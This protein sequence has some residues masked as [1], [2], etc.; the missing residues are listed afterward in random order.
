MTA[1]N[2]VDFCEEDFEDIGEAECYRHRTSSLCDP[3]VKIQLMNGCLLQLNVDY[4]YL[5]S[6]DNLDDFDQKWNLLTPEELA[7]CMHLTFKELNQNLTGIVTCL[8]CRS[9]VKHV[10][11]RAQARTYA[12]EQDQISDQQIYP[13]C[14]HGPNCVSLH[15]RFMCKCHSS[16]TYNL[17]NQHSYYPEESKSRKT[18]QTLCPFHKKC[19]QKLD[20]SWVDLWD[21]LNNEQR[22]KITQLQRIPFE[23]RLKRYV[24]CSDCFKQIYAAYALI[25]SIS[26]QVEFNWDESRLQHTNGFSLTVTEEKIFLPM[27]LKHIAELMSKAEDEVN[28]HPERDH[29]RG[30]RRSLHMV[31]VVLGMMLWEQ[32]ESLWLQVRRE[33]HAMQCFVRVCLKCFQKKIELKIHERAGAAQLKALIDSLENEK[34][35][36]N[37]KKKKKRRNK[38]RARKKLAVSSTSQEISKFDSDTESIGE[39]KEDVDTDSPDSQKENI[40]EGSPTVSKL[41][42]SIPIQSPCKRLCATSDPGEVRLKW[43]E[44]ELL[45]LEAL[46]WSEQNRNAWEAEPLANQ[47]QI[48][49]ELEVVPSER[50]RCQ[51][52]LLKSWKNFCDIR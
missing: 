40:E 17:L 37:V 45:F 52:S 2:V 33:E 29:T 35:A 41:P 47:E 9:C 39:K 10:M 43:N 32:F 3:Y 23:K 31:Q 51:Q 21:K 19:R 34:N 24:N 42:P 16:R 15:E 7:Q 49:L 46:G 27:Q 48:T 38:K 50:Q 25:S 22:R 1:D 26:E 36:E 12:H 20:C 28:W 6:P 11:R 44:A 14:W 13:L 8:R 5:G 30:W 4:D 18:K